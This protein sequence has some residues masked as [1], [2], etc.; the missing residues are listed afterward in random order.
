[1]PEWGCMR[2][3]CSA[4]SAYRPLNLLEEIV[5]EVRRECFT[6]L[7]VATMVPYPAVGAEPKGFLHLES[8]RKQTNNFRIDGFEF[9][10]KRDKEAYS[11][12]L[13]TNPKDQDCD[14]FISYR[15]EPPY[16]KQVARI[17]F[18]K[19]SVIPST[20]RSDDFIRVYLD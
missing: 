20:E 14:V 13:G 4:T 8:L 5:E 10:V 6:S 11:K 16:Q 9:D 3:D 12:F 19:L 1:M 15:W 7:R 18:N 2:V 17:L